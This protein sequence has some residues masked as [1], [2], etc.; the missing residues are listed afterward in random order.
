MLND[1]KKLGIPLVFS[2]F[3]CNFATCLKNNSIMTIGR[4]TAKTYTT[5]PDGTKFTIDCES[6]GSGVDKH[7]LRIVFY[8]NTGE[9]DFFFVYDNGKE[10]IGVILAAEEKRLWREVVLEKLGMVGKTHITTS[11]CFNVI[12]ECPDTATLNELEDYVGKM[13]LTVPQEK[14]QF[15]TRLMKG[16]Y[17]KK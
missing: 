3:L 4:H 8:R 10:T 17:M 15:K 5:S 11:I 16:A 9:I 7:H 6:H 1:V 2:T 13:F 12:I 14:T